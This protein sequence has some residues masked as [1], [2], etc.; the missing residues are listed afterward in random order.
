MDRK[1]PVVHGAPN[2]GMDRLPARPENRAGSSP[3]RTQIV[4]SAPN[5]RRVRTSRC[6]LPVYLRRSR[7]FVKGME[8]SSSRGPR[9]SVIPSKSSEHLLIAEMN[10][11]LFIAQTAAWVRL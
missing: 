11:L 1:Y 7:T 10:E 9:G 3:S 8:A 2:A 6:R 4:E 5:L